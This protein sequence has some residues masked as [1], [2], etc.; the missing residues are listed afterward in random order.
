MVAVEEVFLLAGDYGQRNRR[1]AEAAE[2]GA[3]MGTVGGEL[4]QPW[5]RGVRKAFHLR[6]SSRALRDPF[7]KTRGKPSVL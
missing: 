4:G 1:D 2:N 5:F 6:S 7:R 3:E